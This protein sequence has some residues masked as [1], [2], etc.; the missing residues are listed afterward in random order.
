M[1][2]SRI[3]TSLAVRAVFQISVHQSAN[4]LQMGFDAAYSDG[5]SATLDD[6]AYSQGILDRD[7]FRQEVGV[8]AKLNF[9]KFS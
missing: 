9:W 5:H 8:A 1:A 6:Y 7:R 2:N 4:A 3:G